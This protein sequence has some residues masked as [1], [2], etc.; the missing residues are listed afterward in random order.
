M[1]VCF[2][3]VYSFYLV[4]VVLSHHLPEESVNVLVCY[5]LKELSK[6]ISHTDPGEGTDSEE[7]ELTDCLQLLLK[8]RKVC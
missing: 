1:F 6:L 2:F 8:D 4:L 7:L 3:F 5:M